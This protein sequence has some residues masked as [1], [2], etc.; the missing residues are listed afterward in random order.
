MLA[1]IFALIIGLALGAT[2]A[3]FWLRRPRERSQLHPVGQGG[4]A[5]LPPGLEGFPEEPCI[6]VVPEPEHQR[7]LV[8]ALARALARERSVVLVPAPASR[9]A[10]SERLSGE[11]QV[12]WLDEDRPSCEALLAAVE[13][14]EPHRR[15]VVLVEGPGA[16]EEPESDEPT[17]AVVEELL[18][19]S[20]HHTIVVLTESDRLPTPPA[21]RL[22]A[23]EPGLRL[24]D[25]NPV[26][27]IV[28]G[29]GELV[30]PAPRD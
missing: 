15:P 4:A 5:R 26:L 20:D 23:G 28:G 7:A 18:E 11:R 21:L 19:E 27:R 16:L 3:F 10:F 14:L 8:E 29:V 2:G 30:S 22:R 13:G 6:W 24:D 1:A 12:L 9:A 25:G 17:D